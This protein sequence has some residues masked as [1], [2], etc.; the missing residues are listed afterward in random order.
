MVGITC[1]Y[2]VGSIATDWQGTWVEEYFDWHTAFASQGFMMCIIG[3]L[4]CLFD[5][6]SIDILRTGELDKP[7]PGTKS[8]ATS[9]KNTLSYRSQEEIEKEYSF[10]DSIPLLGE[11]CTLLSNGLYVLITATIT[12]LFF[13]ATGLQFWT[14]SYFIQIL[15]VEPL[16]AQLAFVFVC[17]TA[18]I[19]GAIIGSTISDSYVSTTISL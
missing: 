15:H 18:P 14:L 2:I 10:L 17:I 6:R 8:A 19:P 13:S 12:T 3:L 16:H 9:P 7:I 5:N 11:V 4:F 1:G